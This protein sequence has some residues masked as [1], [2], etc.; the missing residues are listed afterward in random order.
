MVCKQ[1]SCWRGRCTSCVRR[2]QQHQDLSAPHDENL[3]DDSQQNSTT[4]NTTSQSAVSCSRNKPKVNSVPPLLKRR[5]HDGLLCVAL[6]ALT[7]HVFGLLFTIV[8]VCLLALCAP[9]V[10]LSRLIIFLK[11]RFTHRSSSP[12]NRCDAWWPLQGNVPFR[13]VLTTQ[14]AFDPNIVEL[15]V[16][17][18]I[19]MNDERKSCQ[20]HA[21]RDIEQSG[22]APD[23]RYWDQQKTRLKVISDLVSVLNEPSSLLNS[24]HSRSTLL[25]VPN[26]AN[27]TNHDNSY[28]LTLI[29]H[30]CYSFTFCLPRLLSLYTDGGLVFDIEPKMGESFSPQRFETNLI[31]TLCQ[32]IAQTVQFTCVG[33][34]SIAAMCLRATNPIWRELIIETH[35]PSRIA[36]DTM[37]NGDE[38]VLMENLNKCDSNTAGYRVLCF[39]GDKRLYRWIRLSD[40]DQLLR[41]ERILRAA[42]I[43]LF[44]A[45]VAGAVRRHFRSSGI[46]HPPDIGATVPVSCREYIPVEAHKPCDMILLPL[47]VPCGVEGTIPRV[48]AVQRRL[49]GALDG[50]LPLTLRLSRFLCER[51]HFFKT[52]NLNNWLLKMRSSIKL[53]RFSAEVSFSSSLSRRLFS[54]LYTDNSIVVSLFRASGDIE[55]D[56][57]RIQSILFYPSLPD[58][59]KSAF[60]FVQCGNDIMLSVSVNAVCFPDPDQLLVHFKVMHCYIRT[61]SSARNDFIQIHQI[62][63]SALQS[64]SKWHA[65]LRC[66]LEQLSMKLLTLSQTTFLPMRVP[67]IRDSAVEASVSTKPAAFGNESSTTSVSIVD[68]DQNIDI[69][70]CSVEQLQVLL[71]NVQAELDSIRNN[72]HVSQSFRSFQSYSTSDKNK[73]SVTS[74]NSNSDIQIDRSEYINKLSE[75]ESRM[76]IFH[77]SMATRLRAPI[78]VP[79]L[80]SAELAT[81]AVAELLAPYRQENGTVLN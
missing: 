15:Q 74:L 28:C 51:R 75:L 20:C 1:L 70:N 63:N 66:L 65:E 80:E 56:S 67:F 29:T 62:D 32:T 72:P 26:F 5:L 54:S 59:V 79:I 48:W 11:N 81:N 77:E 39:S 18:R 8:V 24:I 23:V 7:K 55:L 58:S 22:S 35:S 30:D 38:S 16:L 13:A 60:T 76:R 44:L 21:Y 43:E 47:Q 25:I 49:A 3:N 57:N 61:V 69:E 68:D 10:L 64:L 34:L 33:P 78:C 40:T 12:H 71:R 50:V 9:I 4:V 37:D 19:F 52:T 46:A 6:C 17:S 41:A 36:N 31:I 73:Y 14:T 45:F 2:Q 42:T 27:T 53:A